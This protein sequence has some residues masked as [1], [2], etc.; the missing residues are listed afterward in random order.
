MT[1]ST[2]QGKETA[3][4]QSSNRIGAR[5]NKRKFNTLKPIYNCLK[6]VEWEISVINLFSCC[7]AWYAVYIHTK[8]VAQ[9][10][11]GCLLRPIKQVVWHRSRLLLPFAIVVIYIKYFSTNN[12]KETFML[13]HSSF[14]IHKKSSKPKR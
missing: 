2:M 14:I 10:H 7:F 6:E 3:C 5:H 12:L 11:L 13:R 4:D 1:R 9:I 8:C